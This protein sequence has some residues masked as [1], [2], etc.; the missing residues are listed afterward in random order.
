MNSKNTDRHLL[1]EGLIAKGLEKEIIPSL[2]RSMRI[3]YA[4]DPKMPSLKI[5][6]WI[7]S[8]GWNN[9]ELDSHILKQS[10]VYFATESRSSTPKINY[11][12]GINE[13]F[14]QK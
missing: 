2:I 1:F 9:I 14:Y 13:R 4:A 3:C 12:K 8:L 10:I 7:Q 6:R 11:I 5:N